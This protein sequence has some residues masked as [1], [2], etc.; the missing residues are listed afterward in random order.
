[1]E[2]DGENGM[3][4]TGMRLALKPI[5]VIHSPYT[6][7]EKAP[8]QGIFRPEVTGWVELFPD[9]EEGLKDIDTFSHIFLI[10]SFDRAGR[11]QLVRPTFLDDQ[12]HGVFACRH[13]SR[14]NN[15]GLTIVQ[16]LRREANRLEVS[17]IDI[18]DNTPLLDI[19]PYVP[20]FDSFPR[21]SEGWTAGKQERP[22]PPGR[23]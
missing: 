22:K 19:K 8:I 11:V 6:T 2:S 13:P 12:P 17:G 14:P 1:M 21:A 16:L 10:Y 5:G 3:K 9:Y 7:K 15:I 20:R 23:E 18:L 4:D